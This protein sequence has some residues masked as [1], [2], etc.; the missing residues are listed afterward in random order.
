MTPVVRSFVSIP[1]G[2]FEM[3]LGPYLLFSF[4]GSAV[5]AFVIGGFGYGLGSSYERFN[6]DFKYLEYAVRCRHSRVGGVSRLPL[7]QR[8]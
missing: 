7:V 6:H 2:I 1:A 5:W 4:V 3:P 8:R